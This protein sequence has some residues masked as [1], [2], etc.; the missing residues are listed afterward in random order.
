MDRRGHGSCSSRRSGGQGGP[1]RVGVAYATWRH[2]ARRIVQAR[3]VV[4]DGFC[5]VGTAGPRG[6][7]AVAVVVAGRPSLMARRAGRQRE[8]FHARASR[9]SLHVSGLEPVCAPR[10]RNPLYRPARDPAESREAGGPCSAFLPCTIMLWAGT[11]G[12]FRGVVLYEFIMRPTV[13]VAGL[14]TNQAKRQIR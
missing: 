5:L 13:P 6:A 4:V 7:R 14:E 2:G 11:V 9:F 3:K 12:P 1:P 8:A 10:R